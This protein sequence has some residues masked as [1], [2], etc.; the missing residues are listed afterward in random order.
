LNFLKKGV[1]LFYMVES[2]FVCAKRQ[3]KL[4]SKVLLDNKIESKK[5]REL[6]KELMQPQR[7][8]NV[9]F[10]VR[11][12]NGAEKIFH[13]IRVQYNNTLGPYK[14]GI[15][16]HP[17]VGLQEVKAL[18]FWMTMKCAVV[19]LPMGG[20]KGGVEVNPKE[21]SLTELERV[22]RAYVRAIADVIGPNLD[23]PAPDVNTNAQIMNWMVEE[24][25]SVKKVNRSDIQATFTGKPVA[26]GGSEGREAATG[27]G[28]L[29]VLQWYLNRLDLSN[30]KLTAA[31]QGIGN[32][33]YHTAKLL[34]AEDITVVAVSDSKG[35]LFDPRGVD[36]DQLY[37]SKQ[38]RGF[39]DGEGKKIS[40]SEL[41]SLPVDILVPAALEGVITEANADTIQAKVLLEMANGPVTPQADI[42]LN[43]KEIVLLPDILANAGGVTVSTFEWEQNMK[44]E[45]W[46]S[47]DIQSKLQQ[48]MVEASERVY[49]L[50]QKLQ[51]DYR[52]AAYCS[53]LAR[54]GGFVNKY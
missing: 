3:L 6:V 45:H 40:N 13:G 15:R 52:T 10:P 30:K 7:T 34:Q 19:G 4:A 20:G 25:A 53:A 51:T 24:L 29:F 2:A 18:A 17:Q 44:R 1:Y 23:V 36:V 47:R 35:G 38:Q 9:Y 28:G 37:T 49:L 41:L 26:Q 43:R 48:V 14:G 11:M 50:K 46:S 32:V 27:Q 33:G 12:D 39:L 54:L 22:S 8:V 31:V 42:I 21:L 16:F 5:V